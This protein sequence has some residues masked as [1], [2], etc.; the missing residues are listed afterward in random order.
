MFG[1]RRIEGEIKTFSSLRMAIPE[2]WESPCQLRTFFSTTI[3]PESNSELISSVERDERA[4]SRP[5]FRSDMVE[6]FRMIVFTTE[7]DAVN[8]WPTGCEFDSE[9][10]E[11]ASGLSESTVPLEISGILLCT[12]TPKTISCVS[13]KSIVVQG[14]SFGNSEP[15]ELC[16]KDEVGL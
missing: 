12:Q 10:D 8:P 2:S 3:P 15:A 4:E 1:W 6:P 5:E 16:L 13:A 11:N 7:T 9:A 14:W